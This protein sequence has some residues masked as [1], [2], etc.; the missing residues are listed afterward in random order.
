MSFSPLDP[1]FE[2]RVYATFARPR[3]MDTVGGTLARVEPVVAEVV[4][5]YR[6]DLTQQHG[7][8]HA[9]ILLN[10]R[11]IYFRPALGDR[12]SQSNN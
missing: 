11:S 9:D 2:A 1:P 4:S 12:A 6:V 8:L 10:T 3:A 5:P 7:F